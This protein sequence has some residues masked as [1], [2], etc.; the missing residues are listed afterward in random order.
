[1]KKLISVLLVLISAI[2]FAVPVGITFISSFND[3]AKGYRELL[4]NCF[5]FYLSFWNSVLYT[6]VILVFQLLITIPTAFAFIQTKTKLMN[7]IFIFYI[8]LMMMPLQVTLLPTYIGLRDLNLLDT[9]YSLIIPMI[10]SPMYVVLMKQ[11]MNNIN[12]SVIDAIRLETNSVFRVIISGVI[13]QIKPCIFAS[14]LLSVAESW[15]MLEQP[16]QFI[17][18]ENLMPLTVFIHN[19]KNYGNGLAVSASVIFIIPMILM[20]G[21][22]SDYL[23]NGIVMGEFY[24]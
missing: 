22:F 7:C 20:Y 24:E 17:K 18:N 14:V 4:F 2:I 11:Y 16:M 15:N 23:K 19:V 21:F 10:F 9:R 3:S 1:M 5:S 13:P 8:V 6:S 12:S